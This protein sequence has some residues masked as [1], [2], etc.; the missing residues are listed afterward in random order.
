MKIETEFRRIEPDAKVQRIHRAIAEEVPI[1]IEVNGIGYAVLMAT[2]AHLDDLAFGF[3][4]A[5]RLIDG[6]A[7]LI[8]V[9]S[10]TRPDGILLR[11]TLAAHVAD[12]VG[13]R[14][15]HRIAESSCGLCGIENLEQALRPLPAITERSHADDAAI[16]R[17]LA[18]LG[19]HQPLNRATGAVHAAAAVAVD[20]A[21]RLVREDV[22]RHNA[23]DKL[24]GAMLRQGLEWDN[25]FALLSSRCSYEL[26]EKAALAHC[27]MLVTISAPTSLALARAAAAGLPLRV[28]A[29][30]DAMLATTSVA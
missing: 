8:D 17:A 12:R 18:A 13:E 2:P 15:R 5:E 4:R 1:A 22:G 11:L 30:A 7:E 9:S 3:A 19:D 21:I 20:G 16:F 6:A 28:L 26:V 23:F 10:H 29:R 27:P 25:G 24:I 14:V